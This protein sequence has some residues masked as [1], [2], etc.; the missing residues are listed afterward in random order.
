MIHLNNSNHKTLFLILYN[1]V[2]T[3]SGIT[4][5]INNL[6]ASE[7]KNQP[8]MSYRAE[9]TVTVTILNTNFRKSGT[10]S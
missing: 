4:V 10:N 9:R 7:Y 8:F 2:V 5:T 1:A 6:V 3:V